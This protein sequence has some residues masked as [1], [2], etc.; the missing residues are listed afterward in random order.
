MV[1]AACFALRVM[2]TAPKGPPSPA[3]LVGL[4]R[5]REHCTFNWRRPE[6]LHERTIDVLPHHCEPCIREVL[7]RGF[8]LLKPDGT[9]YV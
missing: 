2:A 1:G 4:V 3:L 7:S 6:G 5:V 9:E 8:R